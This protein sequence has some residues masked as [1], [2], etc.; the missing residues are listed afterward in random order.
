MDRVLRAMLK[1]GEFRDVPPARSAR[2]QRSAAKGT[3]P[4]TCLPSALVRA[5]L[6]GWVLQAKG[7]AGCPDFYF[8]EDRLAIFV[9]GCFWHGCPQCGHVP[10]ANSE[11]WA[12]KIREPGERP[13]H[14]SVVAGTRLPCSSVPRARLAETAPNLRRANTQG[15]KTCK[16]IVPMYLIENPVL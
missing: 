8:A 3:D 1:G 16:E 9:D 6:R 5:G 12:A 13:K 10:K 14:I 4:L 15:D 7:I 11:F 2:W